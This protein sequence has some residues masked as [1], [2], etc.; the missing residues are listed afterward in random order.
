MTPILYIMIQA[1]VTLLFAAALLHK[2]ADIRQF[3]TV[4]RDYRIVPQTGTKAAAYMVLLAEGVAVL[5]L[6]IRPAEGGILAAS[7]LSAYALGMGVNIMRGRVYI[8]CG[9]HW[10][11]QRQ[12]QKNAKHML[13]LNLIF[14]NMGLAVLALTL[15][16]TPLYLTIAPPIGADYL[17]AVS[18]AIFFFTAYMVADILIMQARVIRQYFGRQYKQGAL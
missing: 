2:L 10:Q 11:M 9:C 8:D 4:F 6:I 18:A 14:R 15:Y 13:S 3:I 12:G 7:L 16:L 17:L 5:L 1:F